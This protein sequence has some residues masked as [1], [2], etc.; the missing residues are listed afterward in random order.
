MSHTTAKPT[1]IDYPERTVG[2]LAEYST[3]SELLEAAEQIRDAGFTKWDTHTPFPVHGIEDAM[4]V[5]PTILPWIV[6]ACGIFGGASGLL[7]Q[8]W[9]NTIDYP[10]FVSG[11][12]LFSL[13]ANIPITFEFTIL[14]S[15]FGA[16]F[17]MLGLNRLP[18]LWNPLFRSEIFRR[19]TDNKFFVTLDARDPKFNEGQSTQLLEDSGAK[20]IEPVKKIDRPVRLP[21]LLHYV[22]L[23]MTLL[24]V[25]PPAIIVAARAA[26][27][28]EPRIHIIPNMDWQPKIKAQRAFP[29]FVD[30]RGTRLPIPGTIARGELDNDS[31]LY[32]GVVDEQWA[33]AFPE[34]IPINSETMQRGQ[35]RFTIYCSM[36]HGE[37]GDGK[38]MVHLR[39]VERQEANWRP[40][41]SLYDGPVRQQP[42]GQ[43]FNA[44]TH[45]V[46]NMPSYGSQ[47]SPEDRW[48]ILLYVR[49]LQR[50]QNANPN[51]VPEDERAALQ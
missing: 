42:I 5:K 33:T 11:K 38:G 6:L 21:P 36:C 34:Q 14:L 8:W 32:R 48:A 2:L 1:E 16:F 29:L 51:D 47:I 9:M 20:V 15:A 31:H 28:T 30:D 23:V 17:G 40:P 46:R 26:T 13:P 41:T 27:K 45:G 7:M 44:I 3:E 10:F 39:A 49:A 43:L 12:P 37:T 22:G 19:A 24:L 4:G 35:Q 25:I 18:Q 50:S